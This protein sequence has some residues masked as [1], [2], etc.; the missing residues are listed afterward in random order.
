[1]NVSIS[2]LFMIDFCFF[3]AEDG[4]RDVG[5]TRVQ[6]CALPISP[7][8]G[9]REWPRGPRRSPR[10]CRPLRGGVAQARGEAL[11]L[12]VRPQLEEAREQDVAA[13]LEVG[14]QR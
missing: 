5:V 6:T 13:G 1:M 11:A 3:R 10:S 7:G 8:R 12:V 14:R 2:R 4:I 9:G